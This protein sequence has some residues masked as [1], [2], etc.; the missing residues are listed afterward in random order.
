VFN[1]LLQ[2]L[3]NGRLTDAKGRVVNF[4][5]TVIILTSNIGSQYIDKM[6]KIGFAS[7][8]SEKASYEDAKARVMDALK[9]HFRP[10]F[11][12]RLDDI[13]VFDI[14]SHEAIAEIVKIQ[15]SIVQER[16]AQKEIKLTL[17]EAVLAHLAKEGYNPQYGARP[18]KR[19]IQTKILTP[20]ASLMVSKGLSKGGAI[21]V[22][23]K[24]GELTFNV[25][26]G[27]HDSFVSPSF[28]NDGILA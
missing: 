2:I 15:V 23:L 3:D 21:S 5:N 6:E 18:L 22:D 14:L 26:K 28:V 24:G 25:K 16:L 20:I 27:K 17:S 8:K 10:E 12:N 7:E 13:I 9:D 1:V 19:L 11:L 4:R